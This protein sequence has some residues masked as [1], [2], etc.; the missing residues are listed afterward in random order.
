MSFSVLENNNLPV[1]YGDPDLV[2]ILNMVAVRNLYAYTP[3][4]GTNVDINLGATSNVNIE[5]SY[6]IQNF[7]KEGGDI[8]FYSTKFMNSVRTDTEFMHFNTN[9]ALDTAIIETSMPTIQLKATTAAIF[10]TFSVAGASPDEFTHITSTTANGLMT[11][12]Q[13]MVNSDLKVQGNATFSNDVLIN[14]NMI[15][16][17]HSFFR[18]NINLWNDHQVSASGEIARVGYG[19]NINDANQLEIVKY[20]LF[21]SNNNKFSTRKV[22]VF[23]ANNLLETDSNN[24]NYFVFDTLTGT[25]SAHNEN[26]LT[27]QQISWHKYPNSYD[28]YYGISDLDFDGRVAIGHSNPTAKFHVVGD[29]RFDGRVDATSM[30][31]DTGGFLVTE[32][33]SDERIKVVIDNNIDTSSCLQKIDGLNLCTYTLKN[34]VNDSE[35]LGF[36]AQQVKEI[37]PEAVFQRNFMGYND[38]NVIDTNILLSYAIGAIQ[39]LNKKIANI[40]P[41]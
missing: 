24:A 25:T 19:F 1:D 4:D 15:V 3:I 2:N 22:A 33:A 17:G 32:I 5:G 8:K 37:I 18:C 30:Y 41:V 23:G 36:L 14:N 10:N 16:G 38:L 7:V 9:Q 35:R 20:S 21:D 26:G 40:T 39:E 28:I 11:D 34:D 29:S 12:C 31:A 27:L 6:H 13:L